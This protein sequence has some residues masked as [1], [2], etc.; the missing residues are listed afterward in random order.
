ME[1]KNNTFQVIIAH[2]IP[3]ERQRIAN[4][5]ERGGIFSV[6]YMTHDGLDCLQKAVSV[7]PDLVLVHAVLDKLDGLEVL[8]RMAE[9]PL[10]KT[11]RIYMTNYNN[12]LTEHAVLTGA[13]HCI[14]TPCS[15]E[16]LVQRA[17]ELL[18]PPQDAATDEEINTHTARILHIIST[19]ENKK[20]YYYAIDGVRILVRDPKLVMR[21]KVTTEL[22]GGIA[23][24]NGLESS[25]QV[26][27]CLRTLT[28]RVFLE[29]SLKVLERY[30]SPADIQ[31]AHV[32]NTAFLS[33][34]ARHVM[35]DLRG[36]SRAAQDGVC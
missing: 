24:I 4:L 23:R 33:A 5:L 36:E 19:S 7:Q 6:C 17:G 1:K 8:R 30:F 20:G 11:R 26:E 2:P 35:E 12:Y 3:E 21:R 16:A 13:D 32:T 29:N 34:I 10:P 31:R 25:K 27:R 22:Y 15:D 14:L 28:N 18:L 9:F